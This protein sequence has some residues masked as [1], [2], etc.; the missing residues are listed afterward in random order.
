MNSTEL[1]MLL[2][3]S[4]IWGSSFIFMRITVPDVGVFPTAASRVVIGAVVLWLYTLISRRK[5]GWKKNWR[6]Y[7]VV[8]LFNLALPMFLFS[9][10]AKFLPSAY[11]AI[12]NATVPFWTTLIGAIVFKDV[13]PHR[14]KMG[15]GLGLL[16][17]VWISRAGGLEFDYATT[18]AFLGV[19]SAA[20]S[21]AFTANYVKRFASH[22]PTV[23]LT[24]AGMMVASGFLL[25]FGLANPPTHF[26][27]PMSVFSLLMLSIVCTAIAFLIFYDLVTRIG[28][29]RAVLVTFLVPVFSAA[30]AVIFLHE[31]P[32]PATLI[33]AALIFTGL[34]IILTTKKI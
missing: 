14:A 33:G 4:A 31:T 9:Y 22:V 25:P 19:S 23:N 16:G 7:L 30:W 13:I 12:L 15:I 10:G 32:E 26:P 28:M 11:L 34:R 5:L 18:V 8:G 17:V 1:L 2:S 20:A 21:Y 29:N 27:A 24:T 6:H 3:L